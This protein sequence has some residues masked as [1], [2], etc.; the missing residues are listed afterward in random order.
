MHIQAKST[1]A[2][3]P[4]DLAAFLAV[5]AQDTGSGRINVEGVTGCGVETGGGI[6]FAMSD[7]QHA[8]GVERLRNAG[9]EVDETEDL[10]SEEIPIEPQIGIEDP[11]QPGA[12]LRIIENA[13]QS[14]EANGRP[15]DTVMICARTGM[16][17]HF[18]VQVTFV[19]AP[20]FDPQNP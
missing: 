10:Y 17:G 18:Y 2:K 4:A 19:D 3:S 20:F 5:L 6:V 12:L 11:N 7:D 14:P 15:I 16:P 13:K 9:Y 1:T 8:E